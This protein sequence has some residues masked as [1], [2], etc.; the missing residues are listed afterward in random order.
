[1][2]P[3][4]GLR[5]PLNNKLL[6]D[7]RTLWYSDTHCSFSLEP[8]SQHVIYSSAVT[9]STCQLEPSYF[10]AGMSKLQCVLTDS[11]CV[12]VWLVSVCAGRTERRVKR[13]KQTH[14]APVCRVR[15]RL[16]RNVLVSQS[17]CSSISFHLSNAVNKACINQTDRWGKRGWNDR[18]KAEGRKNKKKICISF[19]EMRRKQ[20]KTN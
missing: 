6:A 2:G 13:Q 17:G 18:V 15:T 4:G 1:M 3:C 7:R 19:G 16:K 11:V 9:V 14:V 10:Q 5:S 20:N 8:D 12:C